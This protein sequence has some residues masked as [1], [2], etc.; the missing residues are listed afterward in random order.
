MNSEEQYLF[1][2][3]GYLVIEN[4]LTEKEVVVANQAIDKNKDRI[5]IRPTE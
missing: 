2:L 3:N 5:R 1:D 4:V